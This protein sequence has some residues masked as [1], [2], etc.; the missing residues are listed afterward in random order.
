MFQ[1]E[2]R[3]GRISS[4]RRCWAPRGM[5]PNVPCQIVREYIYAYLCGGI[6]S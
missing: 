3:F 5:R 1:D 2:G 4:P 6:P